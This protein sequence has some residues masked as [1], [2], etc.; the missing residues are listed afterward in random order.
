VHVRKTIAL[1]YKNYTVHT[2][3]LRGKSEEML[4]AVSTLTSL[5]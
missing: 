4:V 3:T 5:L 1:C 2:N